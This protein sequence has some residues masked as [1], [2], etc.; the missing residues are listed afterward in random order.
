[1]NLNQITLLKKN[2]VQ[3]FPDSDRYCCGFAIKSSS[4]NKLHKISFDKAPN[5]GYWCCSCPAG[6]TKGKCRHLEA[7]GLRGRASGRDLDT[8]KALGLL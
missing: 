1:M 8:L 7:C 5:A 3:T 2:A 4:S 6:C